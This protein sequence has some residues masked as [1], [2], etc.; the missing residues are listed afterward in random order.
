[1]TNKT[2]LEQITLMKW[3]VEIDADISTLE[4]LIKPVDEITFK[5]MQDELR[6][7]YMEVMARLFSNLLKTSKQL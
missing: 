3:A 5:V 4:R 2:L 7:K 6:L 1:M